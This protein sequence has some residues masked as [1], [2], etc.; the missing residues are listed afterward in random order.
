MNF[1]IQPGTVT[2]LVGENGSGKSTLLKTLM[3]LIHVDRAIVLAFNQHILE[4]EDWKK[5]IAYQPQTTYGY[6]AFNGHDLKELT[7]HWYPNFD[8]QLF[9]DMVNKLNIPLNKKYSKLSQGMQ[10]KLVLTLTIPR[11]TKILILDEPMTFMDIPAKNYITNL[12]VEWMEAGDRSIILASHQAEDIKKL[13]DYLLIV[14][15]GQI[16][17]ASCRERERRWLAEIL[18][19]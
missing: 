5:N 7:A 12:L 17:R 9:K 1:S 13:A 3:N 6:D 4:E 10:Q 15:N 16:G 11:N 2:A 18:V 8:E 19:K 14:N